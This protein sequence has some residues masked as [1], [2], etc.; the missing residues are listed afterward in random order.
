M[1]GEVFLVRLLR[2]TLVAASL[3]LA[4]LGFVASPALAEGK[5]L[6]NLTIG[7]TTFDRAGHATV[8]LT[9]DCTPEVVNVLFNIFVSQ[10]RGD[11]TRVTGDS[12][13]WGSC[14]NG[15]ATTT[16]Q[17]TPYSGKFRGGPANISAVATYCFLEIEDCDTSSA[18][19]ERILRGR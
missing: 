2:S 11:S 6:S 7:S 5:Y 8:E 18:R 10:D 17:V 19:G 9:V 1:D 13:L 12:E 4:M 15:V 3:A 14:T 16:A